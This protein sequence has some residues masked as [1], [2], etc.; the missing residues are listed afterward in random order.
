MNGEEPAIVGC[1]RVCYKGWWAEQSLILGRVMGCNAISIK[2]LS[3]L[4]LLTP[5]HS[6]RPFPTSQQSVLHTG[7]GILLVYC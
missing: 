2:L 6:E 3:L 1:T 5:T 4:L 7:G